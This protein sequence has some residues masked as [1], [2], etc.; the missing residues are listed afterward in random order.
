MWYDELH[1][2]RHERLGYPR[3]HRYHKL[4]SECSID[5]HIHRWKFFGVGRHIKNA[6][7]LLNIN[8]YALQS[9]CFRP[10]CGFCTSTS[11]Y[12]WWAS[13]LNNTRWF[14][15]PFI[16]NNRIFCMWSFSRYNNSH[17][18]G[19]IFGSSLSH[20]ICYISDKSPCQMYTS[21]NLVDRVSRLRI[22]LLEGE[23]KN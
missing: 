3:N 7:H 6:F 15:I 17:K 23:S 12:C 14:I 8:D 21:V 10:A 13:E 16:S 1:W 22:L 2:K 9:C 19:S 5:A 18:R 4:C 20:A 11:L